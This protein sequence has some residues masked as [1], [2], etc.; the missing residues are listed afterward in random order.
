LPLDRKTSATDR[1]GEFPISLWSNIVH[2]RDISLTKSFVPLLNIS[3][4]QWGTIMAKLKH[5]FL[6]EPTCGYGHAHPLAGNTDLSHVGPLRYSSP[7]PWILAVTISLGMWA[8]LAW[9]VWA[10]A[11]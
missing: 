4:R 11:T 2:N 9:L 6:H 8:S 7:R 3:C 5:Q 1:E 10:Y